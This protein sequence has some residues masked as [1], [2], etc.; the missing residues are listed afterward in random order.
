MM[1]WCLTLLVWT[2]T[3]EFIPQRFKILRWIIILCHAFAV[4]LLYSMLHWIVYFL[5]LEGGFI[6][7]LLHMLCSCIWSLVWADPS[8]IPSGLCA[9]N[10]CFFLC[11]YWPLKLSGVGNKFGLAPDGYISDVSFEGVLVNPFADLFWFRISSGLA[12][13]G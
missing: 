10:L 1:I 5:A 9:A 7:G 13:F 12:D 3:L 2:L 8:H 6:L 4:F 11:L